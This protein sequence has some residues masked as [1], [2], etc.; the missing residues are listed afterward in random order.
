MTQGEKSPGDGEACEI[1]PELLGN[2]THLGDLFVGKT[3]A[4]ANLN[5]SDEV[6]RESGMPIPG[7][8]DY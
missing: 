5:A 7:D 3:I 6:G 8:P 4:E 2:L 1:S